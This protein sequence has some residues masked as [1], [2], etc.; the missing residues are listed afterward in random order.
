MTILSW[1]YCCSGQNG[2]SEVRGKKRA[3]IGRQLWVSAGELLLP[4]PVGQIWDTNRGSLTPHPTSFEV[5]GLLC[6]LFHI[7]MKQDKKNQ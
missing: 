1:M 4:E 3:N 6:P 5:N 2:V 7:N